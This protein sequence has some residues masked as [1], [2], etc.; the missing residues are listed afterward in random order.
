MN[1]AESL[2]GPST[3][4]NDPRLTRQGRSLRK[5]KLDEIP[6]FINVLRGDMSVVGPRPQVEQYTKLYTAEEMIILL[7]RPGIVDFASLRFINLDEILGDERVDEK[8]YREIE[9]EKNRL[10][11]KY[12]KEHNFAMDCRI[13][14]LTSVHL[15][16]IN[17]LWNSRS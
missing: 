3:A 12:A 9:P 15:L 5:H 8:Y 11:V 7:V 10:R 4:H 1:L 13:L 17:S 6:Q 14:L 16:R 2:G